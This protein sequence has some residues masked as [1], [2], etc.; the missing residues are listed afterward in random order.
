MLH[1]WSTTSSVARGCSKRSSWICNKSGV[2]RR[3]TVK[4]SNCDNSAVAICD[5]HRGQEVQL[6]K[7]VKLS[8]S[9]NR[10]LSYKGEKFPCFVAILELKLQGLSSGRPLGSRGWLVV[11]YPNT[12]GIGAGASFGICL[13]CILKDSLW[14]QVLQQDSV[15]I[16]KHKCVLY[17]PQQAPQKNLFFL[18]VLKR[19][20]K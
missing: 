4:N 5:W 19:K 18:T 16:F 6:Q 15:H 14:N 8:A 7:G 12:L 2:R 3:H 11:A 17:L 10:S 20:K 9:R 13:W 1:G